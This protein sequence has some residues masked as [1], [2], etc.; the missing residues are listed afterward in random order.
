MR[1]SL[2]PGGGFVPLGHEEIRF[3]L[4][5]FCIQFSDSARLLYVAYY[6]PTNDPN[7]DERMRNLWAFAVAVSRFLLLFK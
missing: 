1:P 7:I 4:F 5:G 3:F 2:L 6:T